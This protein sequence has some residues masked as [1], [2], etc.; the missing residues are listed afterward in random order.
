[1]AL[2]SQDQPY[3][4]RQVALPFHG[5]PRRF[6][7]TES[8]IKRQ[9]AS[10]PWWRGMSLFARRRTKKATGIEVRHKALKTKVFSSPL[11]CKRGAFLSRS[12]VEIRTAQHNVLLDSIRILRHLDKQNGRRIFEFD[13]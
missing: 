11:G 2:G 4:N 3:A 10:Q 6:I 13:V 7:E 9:R 12:K 8:F 1:M 5:L